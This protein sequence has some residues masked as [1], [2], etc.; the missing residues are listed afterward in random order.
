MEAREDQRARLIVVA[1]MHAPQE[2]HR[3]AG[4][5]EAPKITLGALCMT[6]LHT[7]EPVIV[8]VGTMALFVLST[9]AVLVAWL[10]SA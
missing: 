10:F 2:R 3:I 5:D 8:S 6:R 1:L 7:I 9:G 4:Y